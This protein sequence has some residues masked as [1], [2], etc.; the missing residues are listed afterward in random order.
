MRFSVLASGSKANATVVE[1][2]GYRI[3]IDCGL[4]LRELT[5]RLVLCDIEPVGLN[6]LIVTHFHSDHV[7]GIPTLLDKYPLE[8]FSRAGISGVSRKTKSFIFQNFKEVE[9]GPFL[10]TPLPLPHDNGGSFGFVITYGH[11]RL[12]FATDLGYPTADLAAA[13]QDADA[14]VIESNHD[15]DM[16]DACA[17]PDFIKERIRSE[18]GHLSNC[19][20]AFL[21]NSSLTPKCQHVVLAHLSERANKPAQALVQMR[22]SICNPVSV[23]YQETPTGWMT[24]LPEQR[25]LAVGA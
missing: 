14:T 24:I 18:Y 8:L 2:E 10:V 17:Y 15:L 23:A 12:V 19:Q 16:L 25:L 22:K 1:A 3:L 6:A 5:R 4:S 13:L 20:S 7:R 11:Q 21:L 9:I